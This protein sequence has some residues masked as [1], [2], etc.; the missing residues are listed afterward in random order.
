MQQHSLFIFSQSVS[1]LFE[2]RFQFIRL[3]LLRRPIDPKAFLFVRLGNDVKMD[4]FHFLMCE[5]SIV[6][7]DVVIG[8]VQGFGHFRQNRTK[9]GHCIGRELM[10]L[11]GVGLW[12]DKCMASGQRIDVQEC[13]S[14]FGFKK[15]PQPAKPTGEGSPKTGEQPAAPGSNSQVNIPSFPMPPQQGAGGNG[16]PMV[17]SNGQQQPQILPFPAAGGSGNNVPPQPQ[18]P[19]DTGAATGQQG[20]HNRRQPTGPRQGDASPLQPLPSVTGNSGDA[21]AISA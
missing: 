8:D 19:T 1:D 14:F 3:D 15:N 20:Q 11:F 17:P 21:P 6:L 2:E 5:S 9:I 10:N 18:Q 13:K 16:G 4:V 7:E 12:D